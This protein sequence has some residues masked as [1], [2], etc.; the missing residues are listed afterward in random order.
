M[1][2]HGFGNYE[3]QHFQAARCFSPNDGQVLRTIQ[4]Q[5]MENKHSRKY[6]RREAQV[7]SV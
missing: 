3:G 7:T 4:N 2:C 6:N 5:G 1:A